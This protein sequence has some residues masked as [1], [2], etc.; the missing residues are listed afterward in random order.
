M[1]KIKN[2]ANLALYLDIRQRQR[3]RKIL[4]GVWRRWRQFH[5]GEERED[6]AESTM[7]RAQIELQPLSTQKVASFEQLVDMV[8]EHNAT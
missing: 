1:G 4:Q 8:M 7:R 5:R 6:S 2:S 3:Q